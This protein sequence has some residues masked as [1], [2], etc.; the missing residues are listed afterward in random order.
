MKKKIAKNFLLNEKIKKSKMQKFREKN[1]NLLLMV[2]AILSF[3]LNVLVLAKSL[4]TIVHNDPP[5]CDLVK[6]FM[7]QRNITLLDQTGYSKGTFSF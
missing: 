2:V 7:S 3:K 4:W 1:F 6:A 5:N